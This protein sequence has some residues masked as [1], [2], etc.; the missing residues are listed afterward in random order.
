[1]L[2]SDEMCMML[3][4]HNL[5][6]RNE[7]EVIDVLT[8]WMLASPHIDERVLVEDIMKQLNWPFVSIE[9]MLHL[10]KSFPR[11]RSN[12]H[13]KAIFQHQIKYRASKCK[14]LL[15]FNSLIAV[16]KQLE[17]NLKSR[18]CYD[19]AVVPMLMF[20]SHY[21][22]DKLSDYILKSFEAVTIQDGEETK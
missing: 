7:D 15:L 5:K 2:T 11:L 19:Q 3:S 13:T 12:T 18:A 21:F 10:Y 1:M 20:D 6:V 8:K 17:P 16:S 14:F 9:R 22:L 4:D